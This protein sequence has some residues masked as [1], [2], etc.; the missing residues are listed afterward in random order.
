MERPD[1][2][3][4]TVRPSPLWIGIVKNNGMNRFRVADPHR[5]IQL[6]CCGEFLILPK[7]Q[8][9]FVTH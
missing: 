7:E 1:G 3:S 4:K 8:T 9:V 5:S 6:T 2:S